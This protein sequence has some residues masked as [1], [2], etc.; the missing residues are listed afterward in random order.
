MPEEPHRGSSRIERVVQHIVQALTVIAIAG[1]FS[2]YFALLKTMSDVQKDAAVMLEKIVN[3]ETRMNEFRDAARDRY[4]ATEAAR[5]LANIRNILQD[6][7]NRI[8]KI[9]GR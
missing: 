3:L 6:H 2:G 5:D 4:T 7:E 8:R 1:G 9:E